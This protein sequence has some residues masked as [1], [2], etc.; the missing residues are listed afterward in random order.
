MKRLDVVDT[1]SVPLG[2]AY[3]P[4]EELEAYVLGALG[5]GEPV[6]PTLI[7]FVNDWRLNNDQPPLRPSTVATELRAKSGEKIGAGGHEQHYGEHGK[8]AKADGSSTTAAKVNLDRAKGPMLVQVRSESALAAALAAPVHH[9]LELDLAN[10]IPPVNPH[11]A[12]INAA[13]MHVHRTSDEQYMVGLYDGDQ[14][15]LARLAEAKTNAIAA[16]FSNDPTTASHI[17]ATIESL[18]SN[19]RYREAVTRFGPIPVVPVKSDQRWAGLYVTDALAISDLPFTGGWTDATRPESMQAAWHTAPTPL[20]T[21]PAFNVDVTMNGVMRHEYG[22]H[23]ESLLTPAQLKAWRN[24]HS[25]WSYG[26]IGLGQVDEE[27]AAYKRRPQSNPHPEGGLSTYARVNEG[28][29]FAET[30]NLVTH[31]DF[32]RSKVRPFVLPMVDV[33]NSIIDGKAPPAP[34]GFDLRP[35]G[36]TFEGSD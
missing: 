30:F 32:D 22:H 3:G 23:V 15:A 7:A 29:A 35:V 12:S 27:W 9:R 1:G 8:Y 31:P 11:G 2:D 14:K 4:P 28:E 20:P 24:A 21:G 10:E 6:D 13:L 25:A 16:P 19:K 33:M 18:R 5:R 34:V 36:P 17:D 26:D